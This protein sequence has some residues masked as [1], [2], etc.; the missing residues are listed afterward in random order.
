M[1]EMVAEAITITHAK[2][3]GMSLNTRPGQKILMCQGPTDCCRT[4]TGGKVVRVC[5]CV[6][7]WVGLPRALFIFGPMALTAAVSTPLA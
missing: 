1:V 4:N 2:M 6:C 3:Q 5:V 7:V